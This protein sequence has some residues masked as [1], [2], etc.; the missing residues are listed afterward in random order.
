M[1]KEIGLIYFG[2]SKVSPA[3][4]LKMYAGY[5]RERNKHNKLLKELSKYGTESFELTVIDKKNNL[6][7]R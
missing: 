1:N 5:N 4:V 3:H 2:F 6:T 7:I